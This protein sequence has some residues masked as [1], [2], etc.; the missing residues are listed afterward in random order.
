M[1]GNPSEK[2]VLRDADASADLA[3]GKIVPMH[4]LIGS[5]LADVQ[6]NFDVGNSQILEFVHVVL[7]H[8]IP[9]NFVLPV[10]TS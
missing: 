5:C 6:E 1:L 2:C 10:T 4:Q 9:P 3:N 7:V 8:E